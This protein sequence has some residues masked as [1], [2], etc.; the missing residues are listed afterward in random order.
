MYSLWIVLIT[1]TET[2]A[3]NAF[4]LSLSNSVV[5]VFLCIC[6]VILFL[7]VWQV[8]ELFQFSSLR[9][10]EGLMTV[11]CGRNRYMNYTHY[12]IQTGINTHLS[13]R[14]VANLVLCK[15]CDSMVYTETY[16]ASLF[17]SYKLETLKCSVKR[18][19]LSKFL[20]KF[21]NLSV[22]DTVS[23]DIKMTRTVSLFTLT[24]NLYVF[25]SLV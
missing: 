13:H 20:I 23:V 8:L 7:R 19:W 25:C 18:F 21:C 10:V 4:V 1:I 9:N 16:A 24:V 2:C 14:S 17:N 12:C 6:I 15:H 3:Y 5:C 11:C 22:V